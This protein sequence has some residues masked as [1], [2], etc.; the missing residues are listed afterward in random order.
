MHVFLL[1]CVFFASTVV[2]RVDWRGPSTVENLVRNG[3]PA[4]VMGSPATSWPALQRWNP[5]RL[6]ALAPTMNN[7]YA[8]VQSSNF[9]YASA[10]GGE[11]DA[12]ATYSLVNMSARDFFAAAAHGQRWVYYS[13]PLAVMFRDAADA[14]RADLTGPSGGPEQL[15]ALFG[16]RRGSAGRCDLDAVMNTSGGVGSVWC[17]RSAGAV[18]VRYGRAAAV[19]DDVENIM[20]VGAPGV[21]TNAHF[22]TVHNFFV[23]LR[24]AKRFRLIAPTPHAIGAL[25]LHSKLH[26]SRRQSQVDV[27]DEAVAQSLARGGSAVEDVELVPGEVLYIPPFHFHHVRALG[28][29]RASPPAVS[30]SVWSS[31]EPEHAAIDAAEA[32]AVPFET[33]WERPRRRA[34]AA[35]FVWRIVAQL[36]A[37]RAAPAPRIVVAELLLPRYAG[38]ASPRGNATAASAAACT[39]ADRALAT[40][41]QRRADQVAAAFGRVPTRARLLYL[42]DY[43]EVVAAW[44]EDSKD[45]DALRCFFA[46][47]LRAC[48]A[49]RR[50]RSRGEL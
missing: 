20:W 33:N 8:S 37:E 14:A 35:A 11:D 19:R 7:V 28:T 46:A 41:V 22:D 38:S 30:L 3:V 36:H 39:V 21:T 32:I 31:A 13:A 12:R 24:G 1:H 17:V 42:L 47:A 27:G 5:P 49:T 10:V 16:R 29:P 43:V 9:V 50:S 6:E 2:P 45:D 40:K 18:A 15:A 48:S 25:R 23:Q 44:A 34:A 26:T 4:V